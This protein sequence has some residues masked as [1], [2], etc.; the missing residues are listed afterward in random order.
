MDFDKFIM[1][2]SGYFVH[3][4]LSSLIQSM[5]HKHIDFTFQLGK[6]FQPFGI[7]FGM[8][9]GALGAG[10]DFVHSFKQGEW[11]SSCD[12]LFNSER[13]WYSCDIFMGKKIY[14]QPLLKWTNKLYIFNHVMVTLGLEYFNGS[15][16]PFFGA[17]I[18]F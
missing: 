11:V 12:A 1:H 7:R 8:R 9:E 18:N 4:G 15:A 17:G 3:V 2:R 14:H 5:F 10:I 6:Y 16:F 13:L